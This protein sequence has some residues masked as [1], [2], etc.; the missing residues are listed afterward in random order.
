MALRVSTPVCKSQASKASL[1][2]RREHVPDHA[3]QSSVLHG[4][5][6]PLLVAE[7]LVDSV[8]CG[9]G[10]FFQTHI[11]AEAWRQSILEAHAHGESDDSA[12][13]A[14]CRGRCEE[15]GDGGN[16]R[17]RARGRSDEDVGQIDDGK[18]GKRVGVLWIL[19]GGDEVVDLLRVYL[20]ARGVIFVV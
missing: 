4:S 1:L 8:R 7:L 17:S 14:V 3:H 9:V 12:Q 16:A 5:G 20:L 2:A 13:T 10:A 18:T 15:D 19:D 6:N 11:D